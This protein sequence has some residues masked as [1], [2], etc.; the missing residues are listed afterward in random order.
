ME[1]VTEKQIEV[2]YAEKYG[3]LVKP[4]VERNLCMETYSS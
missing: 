3:E 2:E 4:C 1:V